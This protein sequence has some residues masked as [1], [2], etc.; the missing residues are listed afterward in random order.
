MLKLLLVGA[1]GIG[2]ATPPQPSRHVHGGPY[3]QLFTVKRIDVDVIQD[4]KVLPKDATPSPTSAAVAVLE[5]PPRQHAPK[6]RVERGGCNMPIIAA[7]ASVDPG[8]LVLPPK[9]HGKP[10]P[11]IRAIEP[12]KCW[13]K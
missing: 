9:T 3:A 2:A 12:P 11:S 5:F 6:R 4:G 13:V 1:L 7:D 8:I 10:T